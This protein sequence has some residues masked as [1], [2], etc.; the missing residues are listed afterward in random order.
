MRNQKATLS[1]KDTITLSR[2][3]LGLT[4]FANLS[5]SRSMTSSRS[6]MKKSQSNL[7]FELT[8]ELR[9][10]TLQK[11]LDCSCNTKKL[12]E[13]SKHYQIENSQ[14]FDVF[15]LCD[16]SH[17]TKDVSGRKNKQKRSENKNNNNCEKVK[18]YLRK[19][20][21]WLCVSPVESKVETQHFCPTTT[22][23]ICALT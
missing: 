1:Q 20:I 21:S 2:V 13:N 16:K 8:S 23:K 9:S 18:Q 5:L 12:M 4:D 14:N 11:Y 3:F 19:V 17:S 6:E 7:I 15:E 22:N 10:V